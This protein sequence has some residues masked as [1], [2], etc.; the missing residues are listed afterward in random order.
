MIQTGA[1][2]RQARPAAVALAVRKR[3]RRC[4]VAKLVWPGGGDPP[5]LA[6]PVRHRALLSSGSFSLPV[7]VLRLARRYGVEEVVVRVDDGRFDPDAGRSCYRMPLATLL[8]RKPAET[9]A[10]L[11]EIWWRL[12][13][14]EPTDWRP[15]PWAE[16]V[17]EVPREEL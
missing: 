12:Q 1:P 17:I 11:F 15:W 3:G 7:S 9:E 4:I 14:M 13:E 5:Y 2:V 10:G 8:T 6:I 16:R